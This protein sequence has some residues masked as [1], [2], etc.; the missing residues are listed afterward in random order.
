MVSDMSIQLGYTEF[1]IRPFVVIGCPR[2]FADVC[3]CCGK[4]QQDAMS[5]TVEF[6]RKSAVP[7]RITLN[8]MFSLGS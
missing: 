1:Y 8:C 4:N 7:L 5:L 2:Q 6:L 3:G